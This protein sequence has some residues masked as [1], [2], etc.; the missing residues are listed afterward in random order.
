MVK[1]PSVTSVK[2]GEKTDLDVQGVFIAVGISRARPLRG[3]WTWSTD[4]KAGEDGGH[5]F[6]VSLRLGM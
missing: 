6:P 1:S 3:L 2:T 4:I 5:L